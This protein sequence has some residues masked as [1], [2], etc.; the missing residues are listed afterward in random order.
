M[1]HPRWGAPPRV[2]ALVTTRSSGDMASLEAR[3]RLRELLPGEPAWLKQVHGTTVVAAGERERPEA[4]AAFARVPARVCA[5]MAADCMPVLFADEAG[6]VVAAAHAGWRGLCAGILER[7]VEAMGVAPPSVHAWMG[8]AI[9]PRA[10]EVG[11]EVRDAYLKAD[12]DA[13][14]AFTATRPGHWLLD[15]Y[16]VAKQRLSAAGVQHVH[17]GGFCTLTDEGRF[18]SY[19]RDGTMQRMA[20]LIWIAA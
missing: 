3:S 16:A 11:D 13:A 14:A 19:R 5:V 8:P 17:G 18:F 1:I 7:T 15:L 2:Q 20:A 6:S 12:A 10:Y 4:D 9:G